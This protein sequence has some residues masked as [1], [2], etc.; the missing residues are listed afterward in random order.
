MNV[1][2]WPEI[3]VGQ[4]CGPYVTTDYFTW[5]YFDTNEAALDAIIALRMAYLTLINHA[6]LYYCGQ[7]ITV[8][9]GYFFSGVNTPREFLPVAY[10]S[11]RSPTSHVFSKV[12]DRGL[13]HAFGLEITYESDVDRDKA[14]NHFID[15]VMQ[16]RTALLDFEKK[17]E[18]E[19]V[20]YLTKQAKRMLLQNA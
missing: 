11:W 4:F 10:F 12:G 18:E 3:H 9:D 20:M 15:D 1:H 16:K 17:Q 8:K 14:F 7:R 6:E 5:Y 19:R 13:K 2:W